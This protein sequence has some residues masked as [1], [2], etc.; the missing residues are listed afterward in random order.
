MRVKWKRYSWLH[1]EESA[2]QAPRMPLRCKGNTSATVYN[3]IRCSL[4]LTHDTKAAE[5]AAFLLFL[6]YFKQQNRPLWLWIRF[7]VAK[8]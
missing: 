5:K 2:H 4:S 3:T 7:P 8:Y 6:G 1:G